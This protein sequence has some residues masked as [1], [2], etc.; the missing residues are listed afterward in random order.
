MQW[1]MI[2]NRSLVWGKKTNYKIH[3]GDSRENF[4]TYWVLEDTRTLLIL[5]VVTTF[6]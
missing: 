2:L 6:L 4:I 3:L 5:L 1:C